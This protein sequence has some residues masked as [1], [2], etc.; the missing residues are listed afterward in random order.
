MTCLD[1]KFIL[2]SGQMNTK[3][4][5]VCTPHSDIYLR[6]Y[7]TEIEIPVDGSEVIMTIYTNANYKVY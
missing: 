7:D 3:F 5:L 6:S 1:A 4:N 2:V